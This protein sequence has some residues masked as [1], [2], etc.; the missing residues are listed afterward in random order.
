MMTRLLSKLSEHVQRWGIGQ[1][2]Q[3]VGTRFHFLTDLTPPNSLYSVPETSSLF[4][5]LGEHRMHLLPL[6]HVHPADTGH[7]SPLHA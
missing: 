1:L 5:V 3:P 2:L 4:C 7:S 6:P